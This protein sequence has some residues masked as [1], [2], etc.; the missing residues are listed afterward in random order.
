MLVLG[1]GEALRGRIC[2]SLRA[3]QMAFGREV[4][5]KFGGN[6]AGQHNFSGNFQNVIREKLRNSK[7]LS[8]QLRSA[9]VPSQDLYF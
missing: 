7:D 8:C 2:L 3:L 4:L 6:F 1:C 5:G 9:G